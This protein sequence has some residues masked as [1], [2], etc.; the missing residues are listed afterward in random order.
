VSYEFH[1][2]AEFEYLEAISFY[3]LRRPGI[4]LAFLDE[5]EG[6]MGIVTRSPGLY[7]IEMKPDIRRVAMKRFPFSIIYRKTTSC[8]QVL[9]VAHQSRRPRFWL[10]RL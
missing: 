2:A 7:P 5:F 9:A 1:T 6:A 10:D 4:G 3:E 8:V